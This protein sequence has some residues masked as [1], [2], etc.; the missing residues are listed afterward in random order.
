MLSE[1]NQI[2]RTKLHDVTY[3]ESKKVEYIVT[4]SR[5]MVTRVERWEKWGNIG[6]RAESCSSIG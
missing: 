1:I 3:I 4:E 2:E 6:Q 5:M